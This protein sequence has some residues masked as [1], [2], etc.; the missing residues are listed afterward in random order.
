MPDA[1]LSPRCRVIVL[2]YNG[3]KW[4]PGCLESLARQSGEPFETV[5]VDNASTDESAALVA[6]HYPRVHFLSLD[7]NYGFCAGN[8]AALREALDAGAGYVLLLNNDTFVAEDF[9]AQMIAAIEPDS[10]VAAVCPKIFFAQDPQR[11]WYAGADFSPWTSR[12]TTRGWKQLDGPAFDSTQEISQAT[13]CAMLLRSSALREV[14][15]LDEN[16][17]AY[18][19]DLDLSVRLRQH[20]YRLLY[21]PRARVWHWDGATTVQSLGSGSQ[22]FR[23]YLSTRNMLFL[24][25]K[26]LRWW[27]APTFIL[28]FLV[29]HLAFYSALRLWRRDFRAFAALFRGVRD[30]LRP[31]RRTAAQ[32]AAGKP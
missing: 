15:L 27:H 19:E 7:K 11:L 23:Q 1:S 3:A 32:F 16:F 29:S 5:L 30:G 2:N 8:N 28:G 24:A 10:R 14:G 17:W 4:L 9:V 21:A 26:H 31:V 13:G 25:R 20:G 22:Q 6:D 12:V 18:V